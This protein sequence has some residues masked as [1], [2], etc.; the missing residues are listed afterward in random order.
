MFKTYGCF[1][2]GAAC[3]MTY[4]PALIGLKKLYSFLK[5]KAD[6]K[7]FEGERGGR[8]LATSAICWRFFSI[9]ASSFITYLVGV[10]LCNVADSTWKYYTFLNLYMI[11]IIFFGY[12]Y[13]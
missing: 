6:L 13:I 5:M 2:Y 11:P 4:I 3:I 8:Q 1:L 10:M 9:C 12:M 7:E